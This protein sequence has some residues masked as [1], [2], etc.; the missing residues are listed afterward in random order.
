MRCS[1]CRDGEGQ[2]AGQ[3]R[4]GSMRP[5]ARSPA[6]EPPLSAPGSKMFSLPHTADRPPLLTSCA[7]WSRRN[8]MW[9]LVANPHLQIGSQ[10]ARQAGGQGGTQ[11]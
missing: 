1:A 9:K 6:G 8:R 5:G 7:F 11:A 10:A 2:A 3:Q 4:A